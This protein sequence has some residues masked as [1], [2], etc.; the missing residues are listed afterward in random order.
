MAVPVLSDE[1]D[2][3]VQ[4]GGAQRAEA[5]LE[6]AHRRVRVALRPSSSQQRQQP[7]PNGSEVDNT[8]VRNNRR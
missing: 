1:A 6:D 5:L 8:Y 7:V 4:H 3:I 2:G